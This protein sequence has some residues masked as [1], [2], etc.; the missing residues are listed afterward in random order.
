[1]AVENRLTTIF[2]L[3]FY[4]QYDTP[5]SRLG[6]QLFYPAA[7]TIFAHSLKCFRIIP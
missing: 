5:I 3:D 7:D 6:Q 2:G 4:H 1:M